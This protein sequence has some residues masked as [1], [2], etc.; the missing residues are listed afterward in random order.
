MLYQYYHNNICKHNSTVESSIVF[1][2]RT[3]CTFRFTS[4]EHLLTSY[5]YNVRHKPSVVIIFQRNGSFFF[6][7]GSQFHIGRPRET[8]DQCIHWPV[9]GGWRQKEIPNTAGLYTGANMCICTNHILAMT[10]D[11]QQCG[12]LTIVDSHDPVHNHF[13]LRT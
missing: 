5:C 1:P 3:T 9:V 7:S 12:I 4:S 13:K 8:N 2:R 11:F 6:I 10:C